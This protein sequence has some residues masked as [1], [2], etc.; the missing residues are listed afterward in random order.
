MCINAFKSKF[1]PSHNIFYHDE[2]MKKKWNVEYDVHVSTTQ[3]ILVRVQ[4]MYTHN[5]YYIGASV[6]PLIKFGF[7]RKNRPITPKHTTLI[8]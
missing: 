7:K 4:N 1:S 3:P 5:K 8:W 2:G 6:F